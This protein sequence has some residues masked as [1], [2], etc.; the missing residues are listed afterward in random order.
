MSNIPVA[1]IAWWDAITTRRHAAI[2]LTAYFAVAVVPL[3]FFRGYHSDEGLAISIAR[4]AVENGQWLAPHMF[5][6]RL[7]ERPTMLSWIVGALSLPFGEVGQAGARLTVALFLLAGCVLI[8]SLLRSVAAS[9]PAAVFGVALFLACPMVLRAYVLITADLP[10]SVLQLLAFWLWWRGHQGGSVGFGR[11][12]AIGAALAVAALMKG[13]QPIAFF[14]LGIGLYLV[15]SRSWRQ[16]PGLIL[17]GAV[18]V[19]PIAAWYWA[20][21]RPGDETIW[22]TFMRI[23]PEQALA[24]PLRAAAEQFFEMLPAALAA[25]AFLVGGGLRGR[26]GPDL[27]FVRATVCFAFTAAIVVLFWPGGSTARYYFPMVAPLC[28]LGGLAYDRLKANRPQAV[29]PVLTVV[30]ALL[31]YAAGYSAASP[32]M[33]RQFRGA[34]LDADRI[35]A[36]VRTEPAPIHFVGAVGINVLAYLPGPISAVRSAALD[37]LA[38]AAWLAVPADVAD[39]LIGRRGDAVEAKL[40]FGQNGEWRLLYVKPGR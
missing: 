6:V 30:L 9:I 35:A 24:A 28:I 27:R 21:Y 2:L 40:A 11:W 25:G 4:S 38:G 36:L 3:I 5:G 23:S 16:I 13:P 34:K 39:A 14:A 31:T 15:G 10:L 37:N 7:I 32:F 19:A 8:Y 29:A 20:N 1:V 33:P 22:A 17:A 12:I 26:A 18:C